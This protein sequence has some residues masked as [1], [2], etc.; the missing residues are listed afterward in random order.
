[1]QCKAQN[2][3]HMHTTALTHQHLHSYPLQISTS[4]CFQHQ[5]E[6]QQNS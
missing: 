5:A 1:M 2:A 3:K 6:R 4:I